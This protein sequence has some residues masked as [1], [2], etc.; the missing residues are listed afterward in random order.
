M[1][2]SFPALP[3]YLYGL[4][5]VPRRDAAGRL[6]VDA[7]RIEQH[8]WGTKVVQSGFFSLPGAEHISAV[9][10]NNSGTLNKFNR[11]GVGAG[12]GGENITLVQSGL[13]WDPDPD[14]SAPF[15]SNGSWPE[16]TQRR[17]SKAWMFSTTRAPF[18]P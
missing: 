5:Q 16:V 14:A 11:I 2:Y 10:F 18:I 9:I 6:S 8:V 13:A 15:R 17:G 12:F 7:T 4:T 3:I 1:V